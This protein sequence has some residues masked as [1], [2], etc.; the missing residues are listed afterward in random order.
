MSE[1][2]R[3]HPAPGR[4]A[5]LRRWCSVHWYGLALAALTLGTIAAY[6]YNLTANGWANSFYAAAVQAGSENGEAM[7]YGSLD[8]ANAIT[9]DKPPAALWLMSLSARI[10]GFSSFSM[11]L[12]Q[13]LLAGGVVLMLAHS[14]RMGCS[15]VLS[16]RTGKWAA[17]AAGLVF[18]TSPVAA[19]MFRFNNPDAL[20]VFLMV[21]AV[22]ATQ[23]ALRS[24]RSR[25][26][27]LWL[28]LA[29]VFLGLGFLTKQFQVLLI[30]LGLALAWILLSRWSW[31]RRFLG[32]LVPVATMVVSAGWWIALVELVPESSRPYIGGSQNNSFLELTFGYN[33]FGRLTGNETGSVGGGGG[34]GQGGNW[35]STGISRL[36][37]GSFGDQIA[38]L[39]PAA[40]IVTLLLGVA[41]VLT[42]RST[43]R[44]RHLSIAP[45][46]AGPASDA[47]APEGSARRGFASTWSLFVEEN[48]AL[49]A[50]LVMWTAWL[51]VT[52]LTLSYMSGIVHEYYTVALTPAIAA[53][54]AIGV[55]YL[56]VKHW[57]WASWPLAFM[58]ALTGAWQF[59]LLSSMSVSYTW[60]RW[61]VVVLGVLGG[62]LVVLLRLRQLSR[63][64]LAAGQDP[65]AEAD[66]GES[67]PRGP[68]RRLA[69]A[70][71]AC[72]LVVV[73]LVP[74][75]L[76]ASTI[77]SVTQGSIVTIP[78]TSQG[79]GGMGGGGGTPPTGGR[80]GPGG[81]G[82][83]G[84]GSDGTDP[85]AASGSADGTAPGG[86]A[87]GGTAPDGTAPGGSAQDG[88]S[89]E[90]GGG[91]A[92]GA[93]SLLNGSE[94]SEEFTTLLEEDAEDYT[95]VAA[96]VGANSA[97]GYQLA[98]GDPVMAIGGFN[99]TD[100]APTLAQFQ[101]Y[102]AEGRIHYF[103]GGSGMGG[104][105]G[106][107]AEIADWVAQNY[108]ATEIDSTTVYDLTQPAAEQ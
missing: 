37:T 71:A 26:A 78:G 104:D 15:G 41:G 38:W 17:L 29:G 88:T 20:L 72:A 36:L 12:P 8:A 31:P 2:T 84:D 27:C 74:G 67:V 99:G 35:G 52:W 22:V 51:L 106:T 45:G 61:I 93:G 5:R 89:S 62:F 50:A 73:F 64:V 7:L 75:L 23:H 66:A 33:G 49:L 87:P 107:S 34:G 100:P 91:R 53:V 86:T 6:L 92:G 95:W 90:S 43:A 77:D 21:A 69:Q 105:T 9:V 60:V 82:T 79:A 14:V 54:L 24:V 18:A 57:S 63:P 55:P 59:A 85:A 102:V 39:L 56:V 108:T 10:F 47:A 48:R 11:L 13:V 70:A 28:A 97:A 80:G 1:P 46:V 4:G 58:L 32:L 81:T 42:W 25:R 98:T 3:S 83:T 76:T 44:S 103:I 30:T 94:P 16:A 40:I 101:Q 65:S 68:V 96:T 19:E